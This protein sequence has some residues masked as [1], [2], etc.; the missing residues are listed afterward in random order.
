M[1]DQ[2]QQ[3]IVTGSILHLARVDPITALVGAARD[4]G[5]I[6]VLNPNT[7]VQDI[8]LFDSRGGTRIR[9]AR[10]VTE[11][12]E[13]YEVTC[14]NMTPDNLAYVFGADAVTTYTQSATPLTGVAHTGWA[15]SVLW[16]HDASGNYLYDIA[17]VENVKVGATTLV[18]GTDYVAD[19]TMLKCGYIRLKTPSGGGAL[20]VP[21]ATG[22][23][24]TV[25][26]TPNAVSG[27][28]VF[29]PHTAGVA[30]AEARILWTSDGYGTVQ[31]RD[32]LRVNISPA[33]PEFRDTDFS[34]LKFTMSVV[35]N[36]VTPSAPAGRFL[37][38]VGGLPTFSF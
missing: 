18:A 16:L 4:V 9:I 20:A 30:A 28:R 1:L 10:R 32:T 22:T 23:A 27:R 26:F 25:S 6:T 29:N 35:S 19:P 2:N 38:P 34:N 24:I 13:T 5:T 17:S 37:M 3:L 33:Q 31:V 8:N 15:E 7:A 21:G 14:S 11:F 12:T 36:N